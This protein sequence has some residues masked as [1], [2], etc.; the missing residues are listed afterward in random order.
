MAELSFVG[1]GSLPV[2]DRMSLVDTR[3]NIQR[4]DDH[5]RRELDHEDA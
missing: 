5:N 4:H 2:P 3:R 1:K